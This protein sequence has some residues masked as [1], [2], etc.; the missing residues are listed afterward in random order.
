MTDASHGCAPDPESTAG[1][2]LL[3]IS[4]RHAQKAIADVLRDFIDTWTGGAIDVHQSSSAEAAG[5]RQ[6][7]N[8]T[9][10]LRRYLWRTSVLVLIYT[11]HD[12]DW[13][14]CMWECGV[15][16]LP[17]P[18]A[19][20]TI[21]LQTSDQHPAVFD[22]QLRAKLRSLDD[23]EKFV[24][25]LLTDPDYFP[26]L[27]RAATKHL[28][29]STAVKKATLELHT[30]LSK[31][32]PNDD[33]VTDE[34]EWPPYP[35]LTIM[36]SDDQIEQIRTMDGTEGDRVDM[37]EKI[38]VAESVVI[39][40]DAKVG[41]I[42]G[43]NGFP[44]RRAMKGIPTRDLI[45]RW[46]QS[47]PT[48][49]SKWTHD[50][51]RQILTTVTGGIPTAHWQLLRG[52]NSENTAWYGPVVRY[53]KHVVRDRRVEIDVTFCRFRLDDQRRPRIEI[54]EEREDV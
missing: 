40:G 51:A 24:N 44:L 50:L 19:T 6:G 17:E 4:H 34:E 26:Q 53:Y 38:L 13:S 48:P 42:F 21:V 3:F 39:G 32:L 20:K 9:D 23:V 7:Q 14:Y 15:A 27:G 25:S 49:T 16:Q 12:E 22:N 11:T 33:E 5:P 1:S 36:L 37:T 41:T 2:P 8:L 30:E 54:C 28:P 35:Q 29:H 18:S 52:E 45:D 43:M 47:T 46:R 10:E 31:V